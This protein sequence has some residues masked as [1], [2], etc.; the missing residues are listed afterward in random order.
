[1]VFG[2]YDVQCVIVIT[3]AHRVVIRTVTLEQ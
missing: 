2:L 1:M 3:G